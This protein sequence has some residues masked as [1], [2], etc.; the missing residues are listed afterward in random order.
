MIEWYLWTKDCPDTRTLGICE[1]MWNLTFNEQLEL[2]KTYAKQAIH[3][4][5]V[6]QATVSSPW[7]FLQLKQGQSNCHTRKWQ[8]MRL[9]PMKIPKTIVKKFSNKNWL[10]IM[11]GK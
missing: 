3:I 11:L 8:N 7:K 9:L 6:G 4:C 1:M 10:N 2:D 5:F